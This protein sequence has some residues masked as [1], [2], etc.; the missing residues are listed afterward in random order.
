MKRVFLLSVA[1][2]FAAVACGE[3][4]SSRNPLVPG[5]GAP[6]P[7]GATITIGANGAVSPANVTVAI[8][9]SVT[10]VNNDSRAH[11]MSS[12][13]HP[14]HTDCPSINALTVISSGQTK[15][16]NAFPSGGSCGFHDHGD[17]NNNSLRGRITIQ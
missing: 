10:F 8:G 3:D 15:L 1:V 13:P 4:S 11:E 16:T 2:A 14:D 5:S 6:G 17:P 12:D 7:S 9:Q